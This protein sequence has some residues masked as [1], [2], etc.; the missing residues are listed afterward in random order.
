MFVI[1]VTDFAWWKQFF[2]FKFFNQPFFFI[3]YWGRVLNFCKTN[4]SDTKNIIV[5]YLNLGNQRKKKNYGFSTL[6]PDSAFYINY[7]HI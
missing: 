2:S 3:Q 1:C 7:I 4:F 6:K 5:L